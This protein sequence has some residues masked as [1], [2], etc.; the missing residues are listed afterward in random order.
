[1]RGPQQRAWGTS[2]GKR[3]TGV[4]GRNW[5][6]GAG[7]PK[8]GWDCRT[9]PKANKGSGSGMKGERFF[10]P[11]LRL[12]NELS[13]TITKGRCMKTK[14]SSRRLP[15][16]DRHPLCQVHYEYDGSTNPL[17]LVI[18]GAPEAPALGFA[19]SHPTARQQDEPRGRARLGVFCC[20]EVLRMRTGHVEDCRRGWRSSRAWLV[21]PAPTKGRQPGAKHTLLS[22]PSLAR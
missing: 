7:N 18:I 2:D 22:Q 6:R 14:L 13:C 8:Y 17:G 4:R 15:E 10:V 12:G 5:G 3:R 11:K 19:E 20:T 16:L 21:L 1:M 9:Q